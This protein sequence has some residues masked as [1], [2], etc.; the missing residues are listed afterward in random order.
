MSAVTAADE[1]I[2][3]LRRLD[4]CAVS[5]ALD[6]LGLRGTVLGI[7]PVWPSREPV[8]GRVRTVQAGPRRDGA[9]AAHIAASAID[10]SGPEH[11]LVIAN[12]A[13][14]DVSCWGGILTRA[15]CRRQLA[16]VVVDGACRDAA[17]SEQFGFP[18]FARA[19]V[20]LTARGRIVQLAMDEPV[21]IADVRVG[22]DDYV[23]AD[24]NGVVF[25]PGEH[26]GEVLD[27]AERIV[28]REQAMADAVDSGRPVSEVM[29]DSR[30]PTAGGSD[31]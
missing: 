18:V 10:S 17:E 9:P 6:L 13:R 3:R 26:A 23:I 7:A 5:D 31:G 2:D 20:P 29:H 30:F 14:L 27:A 12:G 1:V 19:A 28:A 8:A 25:I 22:P 24:V 4:A 11:V 21:T 16:G 15:A